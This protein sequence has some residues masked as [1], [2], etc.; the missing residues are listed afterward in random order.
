MTRDNILADKSINFAIRMAKCY[1]YLME[2]RKEFI[3][4][5]QMLRSGTSIGAN[6]RESVNAQSKL[7][8]INKLNIALKES[9]ET[10]YW[11]ELLYE[12]DYIEEKM[13]NSFITDN[14]NISGTLV[15]IIKST[16]NNINNINNPKIESDNG[17]DEGA[18]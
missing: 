17:E 1:S 18:A 7:D 10:E 11:L 12:T 5:K 6:V 14:H 4:S 2:E 13:F 16:K 8:F 9:N 3:M 15:N